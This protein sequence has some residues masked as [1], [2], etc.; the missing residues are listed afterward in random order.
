MVS[1]FGYAFLS[2]DFIFCL[3]AFLIFVKLVDYNNY[4]LSQQKLY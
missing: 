1:F 3:N 2:Q 4:Y